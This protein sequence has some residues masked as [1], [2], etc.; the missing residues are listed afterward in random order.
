MSPS[1]LSLIKRMIVEVIS[2]YWFSI[3]CS[4]VLM[5]IIAS[6]NSFQALLIQ[7][8][9]DQTLFKSGN[10]DTDFLFQ[11]PI[12]IIVVTIAKGLAT[13]YQ[14]VL[15]TK[16]TTKMTNDLRLRLYTKYLKSDIEYFNSSSSATMM[17]S[18]YNDVQGMMGGINLL[19]SGVF[20]NF[21][22]VIFLFGVM[23][24]QNP[25]LTLV[26]LVG[27]PLAVYPIYVVYRK[28][29]KYMN[30]NQEQ[31]ANF[32]V[33]MDDSLRGV[34]VV[35]SYNAEDY[36][37]GRM[38]K[39]LLGLFN[40]NWKISRVSN[41]PGPLNEALVGVGT[42]AVL[43]YGGSLVMNGHSTPGS[44]FSFFAALMMA[45]KPMKAVGGLNI[46]LQMC[47]VCA[48]RVFDILDTK[49]K[50]VDKPNAIELGKV[51][52][53]IKFDEVT[54]TYTGDKNALNAI[55]FDIESGKTYA[56]VGHSG[57]GKSTIMSL[58]LRFY[59]PTKGSIFI[60]GN[61]IKDIRLKSLRDH[62][63]FVGQ[64]VQLFDDSIM[65]N[66]KYSKQDASE[67]DIINAA[68]M[69]EAHDFIMEQPN[70]YATQ[71][72]Q[73]G[74]KLSGGQRQRISIARAIL[75]NT[76]ILLLDEATSALDPVSEKLVQKAITHLMK[77]KTTLVI[78]HR[79]ST[80][81][82]ADKIFVVNN[83][84]IV[85]QGNHEQL[86]AKNGEYAILY[87]KQFQD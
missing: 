81:I 9:V 6:T 69:A 39:T 63:S 76:P 82:N 54:F 14:Q 2:P 34:K 68:K 71:I 30:R 70:K 37:I 62:I 4:V 66:I 31:L 35:K 21:F 41:I 60:D 73:N 86:L 12:M 48:K 28:V 42:A 53:N 57:G 74:Q 33:L 56:F 55:S 17:A 29:D 1:R 16:V 49:E 44:F 19:I 43:Y 15:S 72:G 83:G 84:K 65:E 77:D 61:D 47:L 85:E 20:K 78:A 7:P 40:I 18:I 13:Y 27:L 24:Y 26:S 75:R 38:K 11:I 79:L 80:V 23:L 5:I 8:A 87:S 46:Q 45:Y 51:N 36:E 25:T 64:D 52:G 59:D 3:F 22:S 58:L 50:I 32:S 10:N 67:E